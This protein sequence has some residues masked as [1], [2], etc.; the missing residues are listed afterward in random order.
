MA[1]VIVATSQPVELHALCDIAQGAGHEVVGKAVT[2]Q[3]AVRLVREL[4]PDLLIASPDLPRVSGLEAL[5]RIKAQSLRTRIILFGAETAPHFVERCYRA[6]ADGFV[7]KQEDEKELRRAIAAVLSGHRYFPNLDRPGYS[8]D[9]ND[10]LLALSER[11]FSIFRYLVQGYSNAHIADELS[12]SPKTVSTHR[13]NLCDKL[14]T[15]SLVDLVDIAKQYGV[16]PNSGGQNVEGSDVPGLPDAEVGVLR[17]M[18][19]GTPL[20][21]HVRDMEGRL[22]ACNEAFL[23][24]NKTTLEEVIGTR[25]TE[26]DWL[27]AGTAQ[28]MQDKYLELVAAGKPASADQELIVHGKRAIFH[29]WATPYHGPDGQVVG[30]VCGTLDVTNREDVLK[31]LAIERDGADAVRAGLSRLLSALAEE[32]EPLA[33]L[34][35][36]VQASRQA[37]H[38]PS[39]GDALASS[40]GATALR[41][42]RLSRAVRD[43]ARLEQG[44]TRLSFDRVVPEALIRNVVEAAQADKFARQSTI[45]LSVSGAADTPVTLDRERVAQLLSLLIRRVLVRPFPPTVDVRLDVADRGSD[46]RMLTVE[47]ESV[48]ENHSESARHTEAIVEAASDLI[49]LLCGRLVE[50]MHGTLRAADSASG[51]RRIVLRI[52]APRA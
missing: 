42:E 5:R 20:P 21:L 17:A 39:E 12:I 47:I 43:L 36:E 22:I 1:N 33:A 26:V 52:P 24:T 23:S 48:S 44:Q 28:A 31:A 8:A 10:P 27:P 15:R 19:D 16:L 34:L 46:V 14:N 11:E 30:M 32:L 41:L 13:G 50:L 45:S 40:T 2:G 6:G 7:G 38:V 4:K 18:L 35:R 49:L 3:Q 51:A 29:S 25:L 37:S 9:T